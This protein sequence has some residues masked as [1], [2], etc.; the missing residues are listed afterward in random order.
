MTSRE[1]NRYPRRRF[2]RLM[3]LAALLLAPSSSMLHG[4]EPVA[5]KLKPFLETHCFDCH[6][7][8]MQKAGLR[9]DSR[10]SATTTPPNLGACFR[11]GHVR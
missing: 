2:C 1:S 6:D 5:E 3:L 8:D 9:L 7:A 11:Q 10:T 4:A